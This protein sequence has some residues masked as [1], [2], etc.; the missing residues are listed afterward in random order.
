MTTTPAPSSAEQMPELPFT[1]YALFYEE[2]GDDENEGYREVVDAPGYTAAQMRAYARAYAA[3]VVDAPGYTAAQMVV[4]APGYTAA[5]MRAY[6]RAY[7]AQEVAPLLEAL[8]LIAAQSSGT[9]G[10]TSRADCM[11][12]IASAAIRA[13]NA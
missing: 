11:A 2:L 6:A 12:A 5:Q 10:S 7:A 4:D 8:E 1:D 3:Q 9:P 13:R